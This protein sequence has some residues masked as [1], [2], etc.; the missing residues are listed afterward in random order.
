MSEL[1][2][3]NDHFDRESPVVTAV[4]SCQRRHTQ[5]EAFLRWQYRSLPNPTFVVG[6]GQESI[7]N[8]LVL[9]VPDRELD[10]L[11]KVWALYE[12]VTQNSRFEVMICTYDDCVLHIGSLYCLLFSIWVSPARPSALISEDSGASERGSGGGAYLPGMTSHEPDRLSS[13]G[14]AVLSRGAIEGV[15]QNGRDRFIRTSGRVGHYSLTSV[16]SEQGVDVSDL[17]RTLF[18]SAVPALYMGGLHII[19]NGSGGE[20]RPMLREEGIGWSGRLPGHHYSDV[21]FFCSHVHKFLFLSIPKCG[22]TSV[23]TL[24]VKDFTECEES[25]VT[26]WVHGRLGYAHSP[27]YVYSVEY[28]ELISDLRHRGYLAFAIYRDPVERL[29]SLYRNKIAEEYGSHDLFRRHFGC[30]FEMFLRLVESQFETQPLSEI[31]HH[32][33]PQAHWTTRARLDFIVPIVHLNDFANQVLRAEVTVANSSNSN[34]VV[35]S[36]DQKRRIEAL[37]S[38]DYEIIPNWPAKGF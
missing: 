7:D 38:M 3:M 11:C 13:S 25:P 30:D 35:V 24:I 15:L 36:E 23:K 31:E 8:S 20:V 18:S 9:P 4:F 10:A 28:P 26:D 19:Q 6:E 16:L 2:V 32:I 1:L 5:R 37:Y 12:W 33:R 34:L 27:P 17:D 29:I 21:L 14:L 22:C